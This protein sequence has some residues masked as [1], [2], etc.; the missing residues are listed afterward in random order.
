MAE[1]GRK[2]TFEEMAAI[3]AAKVF[4]T[5]VS[6]KVLVDSMPEITR[7]RQRIVHLEESLAF[8]ETVCPP[9]ITEA[10]G[11]PDD[12]YCDACQSCL[13]CMDWRQNRCKL[14]CQ[15]HGVREDCSECNGNF[16]D[17]CIQECPA[18]GDFYCPNCLEEHAQECNECRP[19]L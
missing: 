14:T 15:T 3:D 12:L 18:F 4:F 11:G 6:S 1:N 13:S 5:Q 9:C 2:R 17:E 19:L 8:Y 10:E 16:C 7:L